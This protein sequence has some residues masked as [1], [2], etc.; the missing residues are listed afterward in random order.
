MR[1]HLNRI[2]E[3]LAT[4]EGVSGA[5]GRGRP[6]LD[7]AAVEAV[8]QWVYTPTRLNGVSVPVVLTVTVQFQL[9]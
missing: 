4:G 2:R 7:A 8:R 9:D 1:A 3:P 6:L 5:E